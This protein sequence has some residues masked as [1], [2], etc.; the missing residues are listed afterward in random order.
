MSEDVATGTDRRTALKKAAIAAGVVAWTTPAVQA[1]T[2]RTA[3]AQTVTG[4]KVDV[5]VTLRDTGKSCECVPA[6]PSCCSEATFFATARVECGPMCGGGRFI[7]LDY[8]TLVK[9][10]CGDPAAGQFLELKSGCGGT[11]PVSGT[12]TCGDVTKVFDDDPVPTNC[13]LCADDDAGF[14]ATGDSNLSNEPSLDAVPEVETPTDGE[15][16]T[17]EPSSGESPP[18]EESPPEG[19]SPPADESPPAEEAPAEG[20]ETGGE[21]EPSP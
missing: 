17:E 19:E 6:P 2:A 9:P 18:A 10:G 13:I 1:V 3:S 8:G 15:T 4:C 5:I 12:V 21:S 7:E 16:P 11:I 20:S 14:T